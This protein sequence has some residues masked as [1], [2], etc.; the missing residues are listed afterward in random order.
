MELIT[1]ELLINQ[2]DI[3]IEQLTN[4]CITQHCQQGITRI[5]SRSALIN[6]FQKKAKIP[7]QPTGVRPISLLETPGKIFERIINKLTLAILFRNK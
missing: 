3:S 7:N 6:L 2:S 5:S 1:K 4:I